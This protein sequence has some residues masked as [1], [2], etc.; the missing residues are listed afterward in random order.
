MLLDFS[1]WAVMFPLLPLLSQTSLINERRNVKKCK[2]L[3][4]GRRGD[5]ERSGARE[6]RRGA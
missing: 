6:G 2:I 3:V 1:E 5:A 4:N